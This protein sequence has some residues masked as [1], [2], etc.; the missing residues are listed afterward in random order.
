MKLWAAIDL[1]GGSVVTLVKGEAGE[2]TVW[3]ESPLE[4]AKRW[5]QEGADGLHIVDLDAALGTGSNR[6][7]VKGIVGESRVPVQ[8]GGGIRSF[9][10]AEGWLEDGAARVVLGTLPYRDPEAARSL[11]RARGSDSVVVTAD[12][13]GGTIVTRGWRESEGIPVVAGAKRLEEQG[14]RN[15]LA[16]AVDRDGTGSGPDIDAIRELGRAVRM[17]VMASGGIRDSEDLLALKRAGADGAVI[18]KALYEGTV[19]LGEAKRRVA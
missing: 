13:K 3:K 11:L 10:A 19:E 7:V 5:Q 1:M 15:L 8:V 12:Y 4:F 17:R 6:G 18:G 16:T 2:K 14:F 9:E